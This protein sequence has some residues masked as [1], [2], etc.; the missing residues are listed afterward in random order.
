MNALSFS[1]TAVFCLRHLVTQYYYFTGVRHRLTDEFGILDLLRK[2]AS[3]THRNVRAAYEAFVR[4]LDQH[5]IE[6]LVAQGIELP[7][8][9]MR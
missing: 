8:D 7:K 6:M 5:Q 3:M 2:S 9:A 1:K 4:K